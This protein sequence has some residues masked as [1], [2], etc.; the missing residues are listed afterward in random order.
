VNPYLLG[1]EQQ[2]IAAKNRYSLGERQWGVMIDKDNLLR[3]YVWQGRWATAEYSTRPAPGHWHLIGVVIRPARAELWVNGK[4]AGQVKLT[5]A[6]PQTEAP[7]TFGGVDDNGRIWQ[8]FV[9][10]LDEIHL[11]DEPLDAE[12]MAASYRPVMT[13]H[14]IPAPPEPFTLWTGPPIPSNVEQISFV[15]GVEHRTIHRAT[16]DGYKFLHGAAI[17]QHK[18]MLYA[19]WA[20]SPVNEN[21]PHE[22]LQGLLICD[23]LR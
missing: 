1:D 17:V 18:G 5:K 12:Q 10:A 11:F 7:L 15:E 3:L 23:S 14:K 19:N 13:T 20:N 21:G 2:M 6:I 8:N 9:G 4:L 22:T 16:K